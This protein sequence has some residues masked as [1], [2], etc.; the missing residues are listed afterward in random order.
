MISRLAENWDNTRFLDDAW[1]VAACQFCD[2]ES[3][4]ARAHIENRDKRRIGTPHRGSFRHVHATIL[5]IVALLGKA[6]PRRR[7]DEAELD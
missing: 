2:R 5:L 6:L 7:L 1:R 3:D 4:R